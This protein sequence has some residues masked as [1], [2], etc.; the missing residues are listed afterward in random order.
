[1]KESCGIIFRN[2]AGTD[3]DVR[4]CRDCVL[5]YLFCNDDLFIS[6][7]TQKSTLGLLLGNLVEVFSSSVI[8]LFTMM[9]ANKGH[10]LSIFQAHVS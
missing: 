7:V 10:R 4:Y 5:I 8:A 1:M 6:Y 3:E 2:I 9:L